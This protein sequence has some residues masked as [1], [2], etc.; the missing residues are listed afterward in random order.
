MK[1]GFAKKERLY[2]IWVAMNQR[3]RDINAKNYKYYGGKGVSV[4]EDWKHNY[5]VFRSWS[6]EHGYSSELTLDRINVSSDYG[7]ENCR[8]V[9]QV[10]QNNNTTRNRFL[11]YEGD[12]HTMAQWSKIIG[13]SYSTFKTRLNR[14]WDIKKIIETPKQVR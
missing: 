1:H 10:V 2:S 12:T 13:L 4:C 8:W 11:T 6:I 5:L 14:G 9:D 3:C 7:P